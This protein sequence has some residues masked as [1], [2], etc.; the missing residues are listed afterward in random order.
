MQAVRKLK[1]LIGHHAVEEERIERRA[2]FCREVWIDGVE[3]GLVVRAEAWGGP[4]ACDQNFDIAGF[5]LCENG[6]Q[7]G[8]CHAWV[9]SAQHII[10][11]KLQD[12]AVGVLGKG[13]IEPR[14][15]VRGGLAGDAGVDDFDVIA[16]R[17]KRLF[18]DGRKG[19]F[20]RQAKAGDKAVAE[21]DEF[22]LRRV[23]GGCSGRA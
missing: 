16:F 9:N 22:Q 13:P 18:E 8:P 21:N 19:S 4:H 17:T 15:T 5:Q 3:A 1:S 10:C 23:C 11:A 2:I 14:K 6:V 20:G 7:G 12:E